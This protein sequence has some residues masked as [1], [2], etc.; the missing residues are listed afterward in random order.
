MKVSMKTIRMME[1][2][3]R[4]QQKGYPVTVH[5]IST[6]LAY[7]EKAFKPIIKS[8][9]IQKRLTLLQKEF[10]RK[11][12]NTTAKLPFLLAVRRHPNAP[13][14]STDMFTRTAAPP[15]ERFFCAS[16]Y[17]KH[18]PCEEPAASVSTSAASFVVRVDA[19][20]AAPCSALLRAR[21]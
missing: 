6:V 19:D 3:A 5:R 12:H 10:S 18:G 8:S 7:I 16:P 2:A 14:S 9:A 20:V 17:A 15:C 13:C 1:H 4:S 21:H 11:A